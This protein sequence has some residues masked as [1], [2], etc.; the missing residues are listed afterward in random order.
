[1]TEPTEK[2]MYLVKMGCMSLMGALIETC[3]DTQEA[4]EAIR[5]GLQFGLDA[6]DSTR[7]P[8]IENVTRQL[9]I[10]EEKNPGVKQV[11]DN[12]YRDVVKPEDMDNTADQPEFV[13]EVMTVHEEGEFN[14]IA[15]NL[16]HLETKKDPGY[17]GYLISQIVT[18]LVDLYAEMG[19]ETRPTGSNQPFEHA[20]R[21]VI[22]HRIMEV[23]V[24]ELRNS[25]NEPPRG[26]IN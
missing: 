5:E 11:I 13:Q 17:W 23:L 2:E 19:V 8:Q 12:N 10:S 3:P 7:R 18:Q 26:G 22:L 21:D 9:L 25:S 1:M 6:V 20:D 4:Q 16:L 24:G 15:I 14:K